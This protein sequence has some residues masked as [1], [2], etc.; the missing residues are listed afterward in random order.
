MAVVQAVNQSQCIQNFRIRIKF[1]SFQIII[2]HFII[3]M[4]HPAHFGIITEVG[5]IKMGY[6]ALK[7]GVS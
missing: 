7:P 2:G 5:Y 6:A 3:R 4:E 1:I